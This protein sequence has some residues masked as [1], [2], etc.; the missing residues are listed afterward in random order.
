MTPDGFVETR[1]RRRS[2]D[3]EPFSSGI[4]IL[5]DQPAA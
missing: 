3:A 5:R 4:T 1:Q 2:L